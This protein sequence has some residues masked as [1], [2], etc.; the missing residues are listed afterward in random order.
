MAKWVVVIGLHAVWALVFLYL[1]NSNQVAPPDWD[2]MTFSLSMLQTSLVIFGLIGFGYVAIMAEKT[3][4]RTA[5]DV[6]KDHAREAAKNVVKS[7]LPAMLKRELQ[8]LGDLS[9]VLGAEPAAEGLP[10][11]AARSLDGDDK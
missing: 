1:L 4:S 11:E 5:A 3:A 9:K 8:E 6:A 7:E 2:A 10:P